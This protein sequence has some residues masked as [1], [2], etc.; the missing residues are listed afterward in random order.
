MTT[1]TVFTPRQRMLAAYEGRFSDCVPVAPEFWCYLPARLLGISMIELQRDLPHWQALQATFRHYG[2][3][4]W[5]LVGPTTHPDWGPRAKST[6]R[7]LSAERL[8][9]TYTL[10]Q[11]GRTLTS[12][13]LMDVREP[14]WPLERYI[15]DLDTDWPIYAEA[16]LPPVEALDWR[17]VQRALEAVGED[18]LLE[19]A[20]GPTF[21]DYAGN[22][23]EGDLAQVVVDLM[24]REAFFRDLQER[25]IAHLVEKT[26]AAFAHTTC[27]V[28]YVSGSWSNLSLLSPTLWRRWDQPVLAAVAQ[29]AH[30]CSGLLHSHVHGKCRALLPELVEIGV[31]CL[32]PFERPP[33]GD[34][35]DLRE[36]RATLAE[37][38]TFNGNVHTV[39]TLIRG[40]PAEVQREVEEIL[41]AF[42]GSPRVIVGTGDQVGAETPDENLWAMIE[43]ARR[44]GRRSGTTT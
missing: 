18:F 24:R 9:V 22:E 2:C 39:E 34:I 27:R 35:T 21:V 31:D 44:L 17:P 23:R 13:T 42:A 38:T 43:T 1:H 10:T 12:R 26:H 36:V 30:N 40:T 19:V 8:E 20:I 33:G 4:G 41:E 6:T 32:C 28:V 15:K 14:A 25:Y 37:R 7:W 29:A 11:G 3:E 16:T 5:G